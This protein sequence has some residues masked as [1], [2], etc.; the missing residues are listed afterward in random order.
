MSK[1]GVILVPG[2]WSWN[3]DRID[4]WYNAGSP[5]VRFLEDRGLVVWSKHRPFVWTGRLAGVFWQRHR[6]RDWEAAAAN[7]GI[8]LDPNIPDVGVTVPPALRQ[9]IAHSHGGQIALLAAANGTAIRTLV[10]VGT[11]VRHDMASVIQQALPRIGQ[12][13]HLVDRG[14]DWTQ[15]LGSLFDAHCGGSP[16]TFNYP[17]VWNHQIS[18]VGHSG[19]L[20]DATRFHHWEDR[21]VLQELLH[22]PLPAK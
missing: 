18:D 10:T 19:L 17:G 2:T 3:P 20:K 6:R 11:P 13:I 14:G 8:Y 5:F 15:W 4:E 16:A 9:V 21:H 7:L 1:P 12:W 22:A